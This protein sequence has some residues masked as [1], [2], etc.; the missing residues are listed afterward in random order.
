MELFNA[1]TC[2]SDQRDRSVQ[3]FK[4]P[5]RIMPQGVPPLHEL[6]EVRIAVLWGIDRSQV[7]VAVLAA[8]YLRNRD[9]L[10]RI[11]AIRQEKGGVDFWCRTS[12][13]VSVKDVRAALVDAVDAVMFTRWRVHG[14]IAMPCDGEIVAWQQLPEG[15]PLKGVARSYGLGIHRAK[16]ARRHGAA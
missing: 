2:L 1:P 12:P 8:M 10:E 15:D 3:S 9:M 5:P 13:D 14:G 6:D 7:I 4:L 11:V 16:T